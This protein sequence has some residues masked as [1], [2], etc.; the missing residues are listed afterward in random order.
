MLFRFFPYNTP[1]FFRKMK[2][3]RFSYEE[4]HYFLDSNQSLIYCLR[5]IFLRI[6][7]AIDD[8]WFINNIFRF[9]TA[10]FSLFLPYGKH[11]PY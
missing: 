5:E 8:K 10:I 2:R 3:P 11:C 1:E 6:A 9:A 7:T 4:R